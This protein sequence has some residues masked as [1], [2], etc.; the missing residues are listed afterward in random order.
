M[1]QIEDNHYFDRMLKYGQCRR[2]IG[3]YA[4]A[5]L[6]LEDLKL[7][8]A[9]P[10]KVD[11]EREARLYDELGNTYFCRHDK[12]EAVANYRKALDLL[13]SEYYSDHSKLTPVLDHMGEL[14]LSEGNFEAAHAV[15]QKSLSIKEKCRL[16]NNADTIESLRCCSIIEAYLGNFDDAHKLIDK[17]IKLLEP[18]TIGPVEEFIYLKAKVLQMQERY[19][20][21]DHAYRKAIA[22]FCRRIGRCHRLA[23]CL[24]DYIDFLIMVG[25]NTD[26]EKLK[27]HA[28]NIDMANTG[29]VDSTLPHSAY[30]EKLRYP[31]TTFH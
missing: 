30:Y 8:Y 10:H 21:A 4:L 12:D 3:D 26:A 31:A 17:G 1:Q 29:E 7:N 24:R 2:E 13:S 6:V 25:N 27:V 16:Q 5:Q 22:T 18:T 11:S 23:K 9:G 28:N 19:H 15:C 20:E 14:Y